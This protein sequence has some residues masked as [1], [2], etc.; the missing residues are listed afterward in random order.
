[1]SSK[2]DILKDIKLFVIDLDGTFY[3]GDRIISGSLDFVNKVR[4][5]GRSF[6]FFTNNSSKTAEIYIKKLEKMGCKINRN[7]IMTSGDVAIRY[8]NTLYKNK[9]VYLMGTEVLKKD[10]AD[11]GI[12]L[13]EDTQ[14]DVVV[15]AF[16]TELT[17][18]KL[19]RTCAYIDNGAVFIAT[20]PDI[21]CPVETGFLPDCGALCAAV[22]LCTGKE[23]KYVG[24]PYKETLDAILS[25]TGF[26]KENVAFVGDRLYTDVAAG[27]NNGAKGILVLSGET[28]L[29]SL[30]SSKIKP[31]GIFAGL[32]EI[33]AFL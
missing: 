8:L 15:V 2:K 31:H 13:V 7:E 11:N 17:Y 30:E 18:Q 28:G 5:T 27:V 12:I 9:T 19:E 29:E 14:P 20:H 23:P 1:M 16:D 32:G 4:E 21:C 3:L 24:K 10:F 33:A 6:L 26:K 22:S 25:A